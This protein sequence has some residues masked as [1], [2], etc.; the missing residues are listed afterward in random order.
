MITIKS[1]K[2]IIFVIVALSLAVIFTVWYLFSTVNKDNVNVRDIELTYSTIDNQSVLAEFENAELKHEGELTTFTGEQ[3]ISSDLLNEIDN[4]SVEESEQ[5][6]DA[7]ISYEF[8]YD[9]ETNVVTITALM[10]N[11]LG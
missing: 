7:S 4:L 11:E 3:K 2:S 5:L 10:I 8:T 1:K 6:Q 9:A